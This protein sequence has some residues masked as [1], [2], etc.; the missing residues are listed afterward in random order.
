MATNHLINTIQEAGW[1]STPQS[2]NLKD[3]ISKFPYDVA[4]LV[5]KSRAHLYTHNVEDRKKFN[6]LKNKLHKLKEIRHYTFQT[7]L[8]SLCK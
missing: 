7:Y 1:G 4:Q 6:Q 8:S 3:N 2:T 5:K